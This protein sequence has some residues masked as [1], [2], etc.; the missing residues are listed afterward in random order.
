MRNSGGRA[1]GGEPKANPGGNYDLNRAPHE[2]SGKLWKF[3]EP[4]SRKSVL[5]CKVVTF[6]KSEIL[7]AQTGC[8]QKVSKTAA[9]AGADDTN[10]RY[11][12]LR[13]RQHRQCCRCASNQTNKV[14]PPHCRPGSRQ[15]DL[16]YRAGPHHWKR[17][18]RRC[19]RFV[20]K[21]VARPT[22][23]GETIHDQPTHRLQLRAVALDDRGRAIAHLYVSLFGLPAPHR[24]RDEQPG[25]LSA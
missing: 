14:A 13:A 9:L 4:T 1:L 7:K 3:V 24:S 25:A 21:C 19:D 22:S 6:D 10:H 5:E 11:R 2:T 8:I 20:L 17:H 15:N 16:S 12:L 23:M 18:V